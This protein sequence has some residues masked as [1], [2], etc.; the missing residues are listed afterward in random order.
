[1]ASDHGRPSI[2]ASDGGKRIDGGRE[3]TVATA[4]SVTA[5]DMT[6]ATTTAM[7]RFKI[8]EIQ[9]HCFSTFDGICWVAF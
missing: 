4:A 6:A 1:M 5:A 7:T 8:S 2:V 9:T 3:S